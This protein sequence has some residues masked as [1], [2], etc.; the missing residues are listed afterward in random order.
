MP[1][2]SAPFLLVVMRRSVPLD[3]RDFRDFGLA[4]LAAGDHH[5]WWSSNPTAGR[6]TKTSHKTFRTK[7]KL[8][9]AQKQNRPVPQWIRLRTGNTI[10]CVQN[11]PMD[12][13]HS[14]PSKSLLQ[15]LEHTTEFSRPN[16]S[17]AHPSPTTDSSTILQ[18]KH[19]THLK[20]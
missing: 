19:F 1:V 18:N 14:V 15:I 5:L 6:K 20:F 10:R 12:E 7:Q 11:F 16:T 3:R 9:K 13:K 8:A 4:V 2:C 17:P